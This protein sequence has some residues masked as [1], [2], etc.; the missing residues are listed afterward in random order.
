MSTKK[1]AIL[2]V[3]GFRGSHKGLA[4]VAKRLSDYGWEC[5][6]PDIPPFG[7][8]K[9]LSEYTPEAY[10]EFLK[11]YVE[12][13]NLKQPILVGHSMGSIVVS[14]AS[15]KYPDLFHQKIVFMSPISSHPPRFITNLAPILILIPNKFLSYII[16]KYLAVYDDH[17][18]FKEIL[19][20]TTI[21]AENYTSKKD[22]IEAAKFSAKY[23]ISSFDLNKDALFLAGEKDRL[24]KQS[25]TRDL[26]KKLSAK[27]VFVKRTGHLI[28]YGKPKKA[29]DHINQFLN[30]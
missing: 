19:K 29:A 27:T 25:R 4:A 8:S 3:H 6:V 15:S 26:A 12:S 24:V 17:K 21:C 10:A 9:P 5:H 23:D 1:P 22:V 28:N 20:L 30:D 2:I 11:S 7:E 13:H 18:D 16:T 14:A